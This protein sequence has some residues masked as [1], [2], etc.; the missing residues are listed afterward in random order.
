MYPE[1]D[2]SEAREDYPLNNEESD[3][4][5]HQEN[6]SLG[7]GRRDG[8]HPG[9]NKCSTRRW[10]GARKSDLSSWARQKLRGSA[11]DDEHI[12]LLGWWTNEFGRICIP[13]VTKSGDK[14]LDRNGNQFIRQRLTNEEIKAAKEK[15]E[16]APKYISPPKSGCVLYHSRIAMLRGNY[17]ERF[18]NTMVPLRLVEG[19]IKC[20]SANLHD[21]K[22]LTIGL[23]GVN[24]YRDRYDDGETSRIIPELEEIPV[25]GRTVY[26][27]FDSDCFSK[28]QVLSAMRKLA[29]YLE[30]RGAN[31]LIEILPNGLDGKR[32]G[33]DDVIHRHGAEFFGEITEYAR[34]AFKEMA[35]GKKKWNLK[36]EPSNTT[37][38][39]LYLHGMLGNRWKR[40]A[41]GKDHWQRWNGRHWEVVR[42]DDEVM[43]QLEKFARL[44]NWKNRELS[45][46][47]SL[48][49]AFRRSL[50]PAIEHSRPG[51]IPFR[52][53][54]LVLPERLW[55]VHDPANGNTW[56]L[57]YDYDPEATCEGIQAFL[58]DRLEDRVT[59]AVFRAFVRGMIL[60]EKMKCF[61]EIT[62]PG[63]TGK[64]V[65][66]NLLIAMIGTNNHASSNLELVENPSQRFE[67]ARF[68]GKC[69]A[70]FNECEKYRGPMKTIKK[71]T[72]GD[73]IP[74]EEKGGRAFDFVFTG[75]VVLAGNRPIS[76]D[77]STGAVL[78]RRRSLYVEKV[79]QTGN[80]KIMLQDDG[81]G[82][83]EGELVG[84]LAGFFNWA[85]E[86]PA[87]E[88]RRA[89]ARDVQSVK[90]VEAQLKTLLATDQLAEW[91]DENLVWDET[92]KS[93]RVGRS[94]DSE[95]I[96]IYPS[97]RNFVIS[98]GG[99]RKPMS[100][101]TFK[102]KLVDLLRDTLGLPLPEGDVGIAPYKVNGKGSFVPFVRL[103]TELDDPEKVPGVIRYGHLAQINPGPSEEAAADDE[104]DP[105]LE[106]APTDG[107]R[108]DYG[109]QSPKTQ[110]GYGFYGF[111]GSC[112]LEAHGENP[113]DGSSM[114][115]REFEES[116]TSVESIAQQG[117]QPLAS[118]AEPQ[119]S[120][121]AAPLAPPWQVG[122]VEPAQPTPE[123]LDQL[124]AARRAQPDAIP[125]SLGLLLDPPQPARTVK[126]WL[127][128][129]DEQRLSTEGGALESS[130]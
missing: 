29:E 103:R 124:L 120:V 15:G 53:G 39:N 71:I 55:R 105:S 32:L 108:P 126:S 110:S 20:E 91:A 47:T 88:A 107:L 56:A 119:E 104:P 37:E 87:E 65:L 74:A 70:V 78:N 79:V 98:S 117:S 61:L 36:S 35:G 41:G 64:S 58:L 48:K 67:T 95:K 125:F 3:S 97:Y 127:V 90:R 30:G 14:E 82:G 22:R 113:E 75:G 80:Q 114:E 76:V 94:E 25:N 5:A 59:V 112:Q 73:R 40:G 128:W 44:Q 68:V 92:C 34:E 115:R 109:S 52:N 42:G 45:T 121:S 123:M 27:C 81:N 28:P 12:D 69:L 129:I 24:S 38:R 63:N 21:A 46:F 6:V 83:W 13:Y 102:A 19:E 7:S 11:L 43:A 122:P 86:M 9:R 116:A 85:L 33:V 77:D 49:A 1:Y 51:L 130:G 100:N 106:A 111:Y 66:V 16:K 62:G 8:S 10:Y 4:Q 54:C 50:E 93:T 101:R 17:E 72:G 26:I 18:A 99:D 84:E 31:V 2:F 60:Q 57:P 118:V 96:F 23:G 89:L